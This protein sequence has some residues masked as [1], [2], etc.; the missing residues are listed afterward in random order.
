[1]TNYFRITAYHKDQNISAIFDSNGM[2]DRLWKFSS[3]LV[4]RGFDI[5]AVN[6]IDNVTNSNIE[7][8]PYSKDKFFL[9]ACSSE[10]PIC[11][12]NIIAV[13]EKFY[14]IAT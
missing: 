3:N 7:L 5:I 13:G 1:M 6:N 10:K 4:L 12:E 8:V 9:R 11:K 2:F 14:Q